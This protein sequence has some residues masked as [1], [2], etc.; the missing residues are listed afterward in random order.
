MLCATTI[1]LSLSLSPTHL[2]SYY[3]FNLFHP[4]IPSRVKEKGGEKLFCHYYRGISQKKWR[5]GT[6]K[7]WGADRTLLHIFLQSLT[8]TMLWSMLRGEK[9]KQLVNIQ[10]KKLSSCDLCMAI[11]FSDAFS[12]LCGCERSNTHTH[13][14]R[15]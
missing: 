12:L 5:E 8:T 14:A 6:I 15:S 13:K 7:S 4:S 11:N 9:R 2:M 10:T 3:Y 1:F